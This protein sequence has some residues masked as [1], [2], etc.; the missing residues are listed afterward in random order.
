MFGTS[1]LKEG[2]PGLWFTLFDQAN[3]H[4]LQTPERLSLSLKQENESKRWNDRQSGQ[5][6]SWSNHGKCINIF[7][8]FPHDMNQC[9]R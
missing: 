1:P 7:F 3:G 9:D 2:K 4:F 8:P 6:V 5:D